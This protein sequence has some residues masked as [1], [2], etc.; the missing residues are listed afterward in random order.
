MQQLYAYS[1]KPTGKK[2]SY[3]TLIQFS[4]KL[5]LI[6]TLAFIVMMINLS[7]AS[8]QAPGQIDPTFNPSDNGNTIIEGANSDVRAIA[9]QADGKI[10]IGGNFTSYN[11]A[12]ANR[13]ARLNADG[14][15]DAAFNTG[16][17][18]GGTVNKILVQADGKIIIAGAF[19]T[20]NGTAA[21]FIIRLNID[22][23]KDATFNAGTGFNN[24]V[25]TLALQTDGKIIAGGSFTTYNAIASNHLVRINANGTRDAAFTGTIANSVNDIAIQTDGKVV[26]GINNDQDGLVTKFLTRLTTTG[27]ADATFNSGGTG[28]NGSVKAIRIQTDGKIIFGGEFNLYNNLNTNLTRVTS[29]GAIDATFD[30]T[31]GGFPQAINTIALKA[32]G[33]IVVGWGDFAMDAYDAGGKVSRLNANGTSDATFKQ[34]FYDLLAENVFTVL[35]Q[36]DG[37]VLVGE[38]LVHNWDLRD[39]E[40]NY[41]GSRNYLSAKD[42]RINRYNADGSRDHAFGIHV[43]QT[44]A[45]RMINA[46]VTQTDGKTLIGGY[47]YNY[48]GT[49]TNYLTR[50]NNDGSKDAT[51]NSAGLGPNNY[52]Y[53]IALQPDG[54][55]LVGGMFTLYNGVAANYLV[56]LNADGTRDAS[57]NYTEPTTGGVK[58]LSLQADGKILV[59]GFGTLVRL[60]TNG[61]RDAS[62]S[63]TI[64]SA[65]GYFF[66]F[67]N[68][69]V[70]QPN[71]KILVG[72]YLP[73]GNITRLNAD[74]TYDAG[75]DHSFY[76]NYQVY[77]IALQSNGKFVIGGQFEQGNFMMRM[78]ADGTVDNTF[79]AGGVGFGNPPGGI[80]VSKVLLQ[81]DNKIL[82]GGSFTSFNGQPVK[83]I[84]RLNPNGTLDASFNVA[85]AGIAGTNYPMINDISLQSGGG[86]IIFA[87]DF[88]SYNANGK[89]RIARVFGDEAGAPLPT[90]TTVVI[91]AS[92]APYTWN[93]NA[94]STTGIYTAAVDHAGFLTI[95]TL[96]LTVGAGNITG[97]AKACSFMASGANATYLVA[98][99]AGST[100]TWTVSKPA[101]MI[102]NGGQGT[103]QVSIQ[104]LNTFVS[105]TVYAKVVNAACSIN[106]SRSYAISTTLPS[107][108]GA[109]TASNT[110]ICSFIG[111]PDYIVYTIRKTTGA[112]SYLWSAQAGTTTITHPNGAGINDTTVYVRFAAGFTT[113]PLTVQAVNDC[114]TGSVRSLTLTRSNPA[115]PGAITGLTNVCGFTSE[116]DDVVY[117]VPE[118]AGT[119]YNW[120]IPAGAS[121][122]ANMTPSRNQIIVRFTP[123][124]TTGVISVTATN[125]C[126]TSSARSLTV[127]KLVA[128]T[129][130]NIT[131]ANISACPNRLYT[132]TLPAMPTNATAVQWTVPT[133][134]AIVSGQG[135]TSITVSYNSA[136]TITGYV[137]AQG[138]NACSASSVRKLSVGTL[139][140]CPSKGSSRTENT[141]SF[142]QSATTDKAVAAELKAGV[143]EVNVFPNP[144]VSDFKLQVNTSSP[145]R[146][147]AKIYDLQGRMIKQVI[148][149][150]NQANT[151][152][153]DL[154]AGAYMIEVV[155]GNNVKT[156][157]LLKF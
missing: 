19:D 110:S 30:N 147:T 40:P 88:T 101:S 16:T 81:T 24:I 22:G 151:L 58:S 140:V 111:S 128:G 48:N 153:N 157:K 94:Y 25:N 85:G 117:G 60:N 47:F 6:I 103:N 109:I 34:E 139:A 136:L 37:K 54:K 69:T 71:G 90:T 5:L 51:F 9:L 142:T 95:D 75:F 56:R 156:T 121:L 29:T 91:C 68:A 143:I 93:G 124:Y 148:L 80:I 41:F 105:G 114:G 62:F 28:A 57:F 43:A 119:T 61:T 44:G 7:K 129:P 52:V 97:P 112:T 123:A 42:F 87:G 77:S 18:T 74:G 127:R 130:G 53:S 98:A 84:G 141:E 67:V 115:A 72:G 35:V 150:A 63:I 100:I 118:V 104:Y 46:V 39:R 11:G 27:A 15:L 131:A 89:N 152:G 65:Y 134:G 32:D 144:T 138:V 50:I 78:N 31:A 86:K 145:E 135:T 126:G 49:A 108:P 8:A 149:N 13:I 36:P 17:G 59:G 12:T 122:F 3:K 83:G 82:F 92:A 120:T 96:N 70:V 64:P 23:S 107:T 154:K 73:I 20:Y 38:N 33:K 21:P 66:P 146:I 99:P 132:Y 10:L 76:V 155:Q 14:T 125:G 26:V 1:N 113:S 137:T 55:I 116:I 2:S 79:N 133:G 106:V 4:A 102:I 45:N